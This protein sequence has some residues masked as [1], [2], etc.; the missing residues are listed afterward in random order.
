MARHGGEEHDRPAVDRPVLLLRGAAAVAL[1]GL[2]VA[3]LM[4]PVA[5]GAGTLL[6][7]ASSGVDATSTGVVDD[8]ADAAT[9][10][11]DAAG[12]PIA[13]LYRRF[14]LPV[15]AERI[16]DTMRAAIVAIEDRRFFAH[17]GVDPRGWPARS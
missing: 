8:G 1:A 10:V 7:R 15:G 9:V 2:L 17:D 13:L 16:A 12:A 11:T 6:A 3:V 14:R 5:I 4:A